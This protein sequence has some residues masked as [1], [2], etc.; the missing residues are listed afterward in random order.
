MNTNCGCVGP[1]QCKDNIDLDNIYL[2]FNNSQI[3]VS[4]LE[5]N[6]KCQKYRY[7]YYRFNI[8][9]FST[10]FYNL[11][12]I[13][14][15]FAICFIIIYTYYKSDRHFNLNNAY[16]HPPIPPQNLSS[17]PFNN[18]QNDNPKPP[19]YNSINDS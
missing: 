18:I 3:A 10:C 14:I 7:A 1:I 15:I 16:I 5:Y 19:N 12:V 4:A 11:L 2:E 13:F 8:D 6:G 17:G 9:T